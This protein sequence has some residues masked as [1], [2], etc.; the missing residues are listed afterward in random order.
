MT[1]SGEALPVFQ[2]DRLVLRPA[3]PADAEMLFPIF[4]DPVAMHYWDVPVRR[5]VQQSEQ[6]LRSYLALGPAQQGTWCLIFRGE[7]HPVGLVQYVRREAC[8]RRAEVRY[9]L[10]RHHWRQGLMSEALGVML[11]YCFDELALHRLEAT[12]EPDNLR[13]AA[14]L[15][16][17]SFRREGLLRG[18]YF[19][20]PSY[21][22][23][24]LFSLLSDE[25]RALPKRFAGPSTRRNIVSLPLPKSGPQPTR[26]QVPL[27]HHPGT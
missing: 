1:I 18:R 7:I 2:T 16:R 13:A 25:W 4:G 23:V 21:R 14:L 20:E 15:E 19:V 11:H 26:S 24:F 8:H 10:A 6:M 3:R 12:C 5:D 9:I 17:L 27:R 22:D